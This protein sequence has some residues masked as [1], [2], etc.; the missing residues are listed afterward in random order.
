MHALTT[1]RPTRRSAV[2][3][4]A[5]GAVGVL[6]LSGCAWMN[7]PSGEQLDIR[8]AEQRLSYELY[9]HHVAD[10]SQAGSTDPG[11]MRAYATL[12]VVDADLAWIADLTAQGITVAEPP[13]VTEVIEQ[14][15]SRVIIMCLD[16]E[17]AVFV[18]VD[19]REVPSVGF[20]PL[21]TAVERVGG[22][23]SA[24]SVHRAATDREAAMC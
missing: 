22:A 3:L 15:A 21:A 24:F 14:S 1:R 2:A 5:L 16:P 12:S 9:L 7:L 17:S 19:G 13:R 20:L 8:E 23:E 18:D 10:A 4:V 11:G 6:T